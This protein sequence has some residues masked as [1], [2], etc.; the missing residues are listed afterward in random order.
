[1]SGNCWVKYDVLNVPF[2]IWRNF[3]NS[4]LSLSKIK[5]NKITL[6]ERIYDINKLP[7]NLSLHLLTPS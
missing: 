7:R 3:Y 2:Q 4:F 5:R 1:M 6:R